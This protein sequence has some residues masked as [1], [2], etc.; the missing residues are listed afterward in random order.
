MALVSLRVADKAQNASE[1]N[2]IGTAQHSMAHFEGGLTRLKSGD[3]ILK[4]FNHADCPRRFLGFLFAPTRDLRKIM[5]QLADLRTAL[6]DFNVAARNLGFETVNPVEA[7]AGFALEGIDFVTSLA[8][9][10]VQ[11]RG[12]FVVLA[13]FGQ[14]SVVGLIEF[15][16]LR[17][18]LV[19]PVCFLADLILEQSDVMFALAQ[20][21]AAGGKPR[22]S[23]GMVQ[24][25][26]AASG[27]KEMGGLRTGAA[28]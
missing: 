28:G 9:F 17:G 15:G 11:L 12:P 27:K 21:V 2:P 4:R 3:L 24:R 10:L 23:F 20:N 6:F 16:M 1:A 18:L 14:Q 22:E 19:K 13:Q 7:L 25:G 5:L 8:D 26:R